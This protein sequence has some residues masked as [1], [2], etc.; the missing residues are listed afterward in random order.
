[1]APPPV[2]KPPEEVAELEDVVMEGDG[3]GNFR[4]AVIKV[5]GP[6][7]SRK[8]LEEKVSLLVARGAAASWRAR[9]GGLNRGL[10]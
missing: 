1:M 2:K 10:K 6:V 3:K 7:V 9:N 5:K 8:V 4:V